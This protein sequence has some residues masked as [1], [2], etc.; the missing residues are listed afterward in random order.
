M[1]QAAG[2]RA[3]NVEGQAGTGTEDVLCPPGQPCRVGLGHVDEMG[4]EK[5]IAKNWPNN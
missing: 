1:A 4:Q 3:R 5:I 2:F